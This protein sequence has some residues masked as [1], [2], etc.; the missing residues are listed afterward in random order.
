MGLV[1]EEQS[2]GWFRGAGNRPV[3]T[4]VFEPR[5]V[6]LFRRVPH[7]QVTVRHVFTVA[8][9]NA[10]R[11]NARVGPGRPVPGAGRRAEDQRFG[12]AGGEFVDGR[13]RR[14]AGRDGED[15]GRAERPGGGVRV[16][17]GADPQQA[18]GPRV[19]G[20]A[21]REGVGVDLAGPE[22]LPVG[23]EVAVSRPS[24]QRR[25]AQSSVGRRCQ[26]PSISWV[27]APSRA[28][29]RSAGGP[30]ATATDS[31]SAGFGPLISRISAMVPVDQARRAEGLPGAA[32]DTDRC[33]RPP[34]RG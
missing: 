21:V 9:A 7:S 4:C 28:M 34:P 30:T 16:G 17:R 15:G 32:G 13:V 23:A 2:G 26:P 20:G 14:G 24:S 31:G 19:G 3:P 8:V 11:L 33:R 18:Q 25:S 5:H 12:G 10:Q 1:F 29:A 22:A 27:S 6:L